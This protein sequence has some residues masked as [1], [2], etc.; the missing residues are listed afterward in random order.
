VNDHHACRFGRWYYGHGQ[1]RYGGLVE[2][3]AIEP[4][5]IQI[6]QVGREIIHLHTTGN[7]EAAHALCDRLQVLKDS[8]MAMLATL[9]F[10]VVRQSL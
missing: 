10:V 3:S 1:A 5:H 2:F 9:Q 7:S 6:H 4:V 8:I